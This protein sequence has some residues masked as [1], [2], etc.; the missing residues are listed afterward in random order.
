MEKT[1]LKKKIEDDLI[2]WLPLARGEACS[3]DLYLL[4]TV[5]PAADRNKPLSKETIEKAKQLVK[6]NPVF[7]R[8][9]VK[10]EFDD[11][12]KKLGIIED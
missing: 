2:Y 11:F 7:E 3:P 9:E 4:I 1:E 8:P 12:F 6:E 5:L 10:E